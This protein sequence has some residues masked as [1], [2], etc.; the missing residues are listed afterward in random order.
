M[1]NIFL[2]LFSL[3]ILSC[4]R[5]SQNNNKLEYFNINNPQD[6]TINSKPFKKAVKDTTLI[7][8]NRK[9]ENN[10]LLTLLTANNIIPMKFNSEEVLS[11]TDIVIDK[12]LSLVV[13]KIESAENIA[14]N[15]TDPICVLVIFINK[16]KLVNHIKI[17]IVYEDD[18]SFLFADG[19]YYYF[20]YYSSPVGYSEYYIFDTENHIVYKT[21]QINEGDKVIRNSFDFT[22][23]K[24]KISS[25]N[26]NNM[27]VKKFFVYIVSKTN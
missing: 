1:K 26:G 21:E 22:S 17:P 7:P 18:F 15:C 25:Q 9:S 19:H 13:L 10:K 14:K 8:E 11:K 6:T 3:T 2:F 5:T 23:K 20:E 27:K 4:N 24:F 12:D 16:N